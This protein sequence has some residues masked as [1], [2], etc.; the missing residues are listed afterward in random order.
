[1]TFKNDYRLWDDEYERTHWTPEELD[2]SNTKVARIGEIIDAEQNGEISHDEAMIR[3]LML[4]PDLFEV[5]LDDAYGDSVQVQRV[6][7]WYNEA[8]AKS[9]WNSLIDNAKQTA[10][11]G[12]NLEN[13]IELMNKAL[14]ILKAAVSAGA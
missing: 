12:R 7:A 2:A 13:V 11:T 14:A 3:H 6:Q 10:Q 1:M 9:Y 5:M 8:K 4:D